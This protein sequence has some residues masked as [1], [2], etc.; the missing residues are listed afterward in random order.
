MTTSAPT[1]TAPAADPAEPRVALGIMTLGTTHD[2]AASFALLD[3]YVE[4][5]GVWIDTADCYAFWLD[6]S[7]RGGASERVLG[8]WLAANPGV[9]ERVRIG[10]KVGAEP[11]EPGEAPQGLAP[12]TI[13]AGIAG[14]LERLGLDRVDLFWGHLEDR[15][16]PVEESALALAALV[17]EGLTD[18]I[19]LSNHPAWRV[20]RALNA[21]RTAGV[22]PVSAVQLRETYLHTRPDARV[23]HESH[24]F[25]ALSDEQRDHAAACD[26]EVWAYSPMLSGWYDRDDRPY[27]EPYEHPGTQ[28]RI[29]AL[30]EVAAELGVPRGQVVMAWLAGGSPGARPIIGGSSRD[31]LASSMAGVRLVLPPALRERLDAAV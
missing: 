1:P 28:R 20:E 22:T 12:E 2:E 27:P 24:R 11:V 9:R 5:G 31:Q 15:T 30:T 4:A 3:A 8:R 25:G 21:A 7:G 17:D 23:P 6:P 16:V 18:A 29:A 10:T 14:S 13:R 19:G 26:L